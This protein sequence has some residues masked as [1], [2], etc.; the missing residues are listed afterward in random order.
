MHLVY[1]DESGSTG[2]NLND[3][4]QPVFAL[5]AM[6]V[7][8]ERW[9]ALEADL[10][11]TVQRLLPISLERG[12]GFEVHGSDLRRGCGCFSGIA[13]AERVAFR[14]AWMSIGKRHEVK[15]IWRAIYLR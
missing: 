1:I 7:K 9:Q 14:D 13:V 6:I 4:E 15:L 2:T 5:C 3:A 11:A 12:D 10:I 8:E